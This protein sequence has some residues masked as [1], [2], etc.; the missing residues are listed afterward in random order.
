MKIKTYTGFTLIE[1]LVVIAIIGTLASVILVSLNS[2]RLKSRDARVISDV[3]Q[4]RTA[5]ESGYNGLAYPDLRNVNSANATGLAGCN[6]GFFNNA[7]PKNANL[8]DLINDACRQGSNIFVQV[9]NAGQ[10]RITNYAVLGY[11]QVTGRYFCIDS[12]GRTNMAATAP[13]VAG[14]ATVPNCTTPGL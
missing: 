2:A 4:I 1:L 12:S 8:R 10:T 14:I 5:I 3:Q 7:G 13:T 9:N 6:A 11:Q